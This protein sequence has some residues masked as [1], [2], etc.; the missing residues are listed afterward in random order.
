ML[1][2]SSGQCLCNSLKAGEANVKKRGP[3]YGVIIFV[4]HPEVRWDQSGFVAPVVKKEDRAA[5]NK[6]FLKKQTE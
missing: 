1:H 5:Q 3:G 4:A 2:V 6:P